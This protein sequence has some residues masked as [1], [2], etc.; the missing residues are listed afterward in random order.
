MDPD[1]GAE[2]VLH[3]S[4]AELYLADNL[5]NLKHSFE[6]AD[7]VP[8]V[9]TNPIR[10]IHYP[11][12]RDDFTEELSVVRSTGLL[13]HEFFKDLK[14]S[15]PSMIKFVIRCGMGDLERDG[16]L[17]RNDDDVADNSNGDDWP[18]QNRRVIFGCC[19]QAFSTEYVD[20]HCAPKC[21]YGLHV[22]DKI[23]DMEERDLMKAMIADALDRMQECEDYIET[24]KL[25]NSL[26]FNDPRRD[27][28][29]AKQVRDCLGCLKFHRE[30]V[31]IQLKNL[32]QG[33]RTGRH[34]DKGNCTWCQRRCLHTYAMDSSL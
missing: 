19:G 25:Q 15:V 30:D 20:G 17:V 1:N 24:V 11:Q 32:T 21:T 3:G 26:P 22:F 13:F 14:L 33:E 27:E 9:Q 31:T 7:E 29:F 12:G 2:H 8:N 6:N 28:R 18:T 23:K 4:R 5:R 16:D 34:K 10:S